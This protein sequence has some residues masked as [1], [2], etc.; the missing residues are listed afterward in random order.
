MRDR[1]TDTS[2]SKEAPRRWQR[3]LFNRWLLAGVAATVLY[4]LLGFLLAP[5]L[6][7][8]YVKNYAAEKLK[9]NVS[10]ADVRINPFLFTIDVKDVALREADN[11]PI[12]SFGRLFVDF[13]LSSLFH[14]AWT[15][16]DIRVERPSLYMEIQPNGRLNIADLADSFPKSEKPSKENRQPPRLLLQHAQIVD[17]S[18]TF[19]DRGVPTPATETFAPLNFEFKEISTLPERKGP[20][21]IT[22]KLPG[23]GAVG[24]RGEIFLNPLHSEGELSVAGFKLVTAWKFVQDKVHL[25]SPSGEAGFSTR[26]QFS[27]EKHVPLLVLRGANLSLKKLSLTERGKSTPMLALNA[28]EAAGL[29]LDLQH[30]EITVPSISVSNGKIAASMDEKGVLNWQK[31]IEHQ[32]SANVIPPVPVTTVPDLHPW[33]LTTQAV[34]I[35]NVAVD[36]SDRSRITPL[37]IT[38]AALNILLNASAEIGN[39]PVKANV[40]DLTVTVNRVAL[41]ETGQN[42]PLF[43]LDKLA[44]E[45]GRIDIGSRAITL[46]SMKAFGGGTSIIRGKNGKIRL[47]ELLT[48]ADRGMTTH[49]IAET[50]GKAQAEE[51]P[52]SFRLND[53]ELSGFKMALKDR[54]FVPDI[55]YDLNDIRVSLKNLTNDR[56]T[57]ID[58]NA[59][60]KVAQGGSA[61]MS[62]QVSQT[63][64]RVDARAKIRGIN[65]KPLHPAVTRFTFLTLES[66]NI[67]ASTHVNYHSIKSGPL[68]R[69]DG[70]V[71]L[72]GLKLNEADTGERFL[73]WKAM[74]ANGIKLELSPRRLRI[75]EVKLLEPGAK[76][77]IFKDHSVNLAK[78]IRGP[79]TA[80]TETKPLPGKALPE[81]PK[82]HREL[83]PVSIERV[84]VDNGAVDFADLSLVL[85]FAAHITDFNGGITDISSNADK[86]SSIEF[87]GKVDEYGFSSVQGR[88]S[89]FF[90]KMFTDITVLFRNVKMKPLSPYTATF[91]GRKISSGTLNLKLEYK[92]QKSELLGNNSVVLDKFTLGER[93]KAPNAIHLPLDLAIAL[94][95]DADSKIDVA[96]PVRGNVDDP[97]FAYGHVIWK[98]IVNLLTK[99][100]TAPF[101]ALGHLFG[102]K[103]EQLA[104]IAFDPGSADLLPPEM[105]KIKKVSEAL[106]KRPR[107]KLVV[108]GRFDPKMDGEALRTERVKR[109]L[110]LQTGLKLAPGEEPGPISFDTAKMQGALEKLLK[111]RRGGNAI[112]DFKAR[113]EKETGKKAKPMNF[114]MAMV[115]WKS[116]DTAFYQAM[117]KELVKLEPLTDKNL[118]ELARNRAKEI[119]NQVK[120][121]GQLDDTRVIA[122]SPGPVKKTSDETVNTDLSLAVIKPAA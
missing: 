70:S 21:T 9:R 77:V 102:G 105:E 47:V 103:G 14:W 39:G 116:S 76:I 52:W 26:Y 23:G 87:K 83:F 37:E 100:V 35:E 120:A 29:Y 4:A 99:I 96:V 57:P 115:G 106:K 88:L 49:E 94:L 13:E 45:D 62:G 111:K 5:R 78:V 3:L 44:L 50:G 86:L 121:A 53:F 101:R 55:V 60:L 31:L 117:F 28:V 84:R 61:S 72:N 43:A 64:D 33:H 18:F 7:K 91:A 48:P 63:G 20:Y 122:G 109:A 17:G 24:W 85:P 56:K 25:A 110:A 81:A 93:V 54:T 65:L 15:F 92:I 19:S 90:P 79:G 12:I 11:R 32:K 73:E 59:A 58:F 95:T 113:Y 119:V 114:A 68:L 34:K 82:G 104:A 98:A 66:G 75:E 69:T 22:A 8:Y 108:A 38:I 97:K 112:A 80:G 27:Y 42:L 36:Y 89:P 51:H 40:N 6:V 46:K 107:L 67:S 30:R 2:D 118:V 71:S 1:T 41:S 10:I 74:S 16:A